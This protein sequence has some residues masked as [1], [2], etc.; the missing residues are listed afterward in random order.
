MIYAKRA[1][2][3][4]FR[5]RGGLVARSLALLDLHLDGVSPQ[6]LV[7]VGAVDVAAVRVQRA[8][9]VPPADDA[10]AGLTIAPIDRCGILVEGFQAVAVAEAGDW[11]R[12]AKVPLCFKG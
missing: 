6:L 9:D 1:S 5:R 10:C 8:D 12:K 2:F 3:F 7:H 4:H 11:P